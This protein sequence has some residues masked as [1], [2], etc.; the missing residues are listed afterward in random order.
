MLQI[1]LLGTVEIMLDSQ[2]L[3]PLRGKSGLWL[4]GLLTL[5]ANKPLER[6]GLAGILWP[7]SGPEQGRANL[8]R[9]LT[10]LRQALGHEA[11]RLTSPTPQT[12]AFQVAPHEADVLAFLSGDLARYTGELMPACPLEW[13]ETERRILSERFFA[14][15]EE[16]LVSLPA[17]EALARLEYLRAAEPLR[18]SF[19][20]LQLTAL[21]Q[22]GKV[23]EARKTY[24][25]FCCYLLENHLGE[26]SAQ[27][28]AHWQ[29]L[30]IPVARRTNNLPPQVTSFIGR[31]RELALVKELLAGTRLLTLIGM[32]G[33]GKT[34]LS[35][36]VAADYV[37]TF[38]AGVWLVELAS[39]ADPNQVVA[40]VASVFALKEEAKTPL[41]KLLTE[42]LRSKDL[43]LVL[44]N[45]EHL[46]EACALL[47]DSLLQQCPKVVILASSRE[48][49]GIRGETTYPVPPLSVPQGEVEDLLE[50]EAVRLFV[51]RARNA[52][53]RF[54]LTPENAPAV[55]SICQRLDG[56]PLAIEL[57]AARVRFLSVREIHSKL[58]HRFRLLTGGSRTALPR[59][60][61]LRSL[62]DWSYDLLTEQ[63]RALLCRLSV[64]AGGWTLESAEAICS[65]DAIA[66]EEV[67]DLLMSLVDKS[68]CT[69]EE[70]QGSTRY[71]LLE[72]VREY[73]RDR[74][75]ECG[76]T[77]LWHERHLAY[78]LALAQ[79]SEEQLVRRDQK[80]WLERLDREHD[81]LRAAFTWASE[82]KE[83]PE[84]GLLLC[85]ALHRYWMVRG[86]YA[87]GYACCRKVRER[88][89]TKTTAFAKVL[90]VEG[91]LSA[92]HGEFVT[93]RRLLEESIALSRE[94]GNLAILAWGLSELGFFT[95]DRG[96]GAAA[97]VLYEESVALSRAIGD[98]LGTARTLAHQGGLAYRLGDPTTGRADTEEAIALY[99]EL[100]HLQGIARTQLALAFILYRLGDYP[101]AKKLFEESLTVLQEL[102]D[103]PGMAMVLMALGAFIR[104][105][106]GDDTLA[107]SFIEE[108]IALNRA[109]GGR[110]YLIECLIS[111][112][113]IKRLQGDFQAASQLINEGFRIA[114]DSGDRIAL[115]SSTE[116]LGLLEQSLGNTDRARALLEE[117][118]LRWREISYTRELC[119]G[120]YHLGVFLRDQWEPEVAYSRLIECLQLW[121]KMG[122]RPGI[123]MA[124]EAVASVVAVLEGPLAAATLWG[125]VQQLRE[126][127]KLPMTPQDREDYAPQVAAARA[128]TADNVAFDAAWSEGRG[129]SL[130]Q[131]LASLKNFGNP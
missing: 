71:R 124:F 120:L 94:Q 92:W 6:D 69:S 79:Q 12:I 20:R 80:T 76:E 105:S 43:L 29:A 131:G 74:L 114:Q 46:L 7:E 96:E 65:G 130:E 21:Y 16:E 117:S 88:G 64:F 52:E 123:V 32:G 116:H 44:D 103:R 17:A 19:L 78:F 38:S 115:A 18:E 42:N 48:R 11:K 10:D 67:M 15:S 1:R 45:C 61:T 35:L 129:Q 108:A 72:T 31:E 27:T 84:S 3:P 91:I 85:G 13:V 77:A 30:Q 104:K 107:A 8:R 23:I 24:Q 83:D 126:D 63:E 34:R 90:L 82:E 5:Q 39:L 122:F 127:W 109:V 112:G 66:L 86:H 33:C 128:A 4:L 125:T 50:Y 62:I 121:V 111:L 37:E 102:G 55:V 95:F 81:N 53:P 60:Q 9:A 22:Q 113:D 106:E 73:A 56:I 51:E 118:L 54:A 87:E 25:T 89:A 47:A 41:L 93:A 97:R 99:R 110:L 75:R 57:A 36:Q 119:Y 59:Q 40:A 49:L 2:P 98:R 68:L 14:L 28:Q 58:G 70:H 101:A 100:G 26:P